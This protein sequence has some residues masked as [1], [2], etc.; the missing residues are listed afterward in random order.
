MSTLKKALFT[1]YQAADLVEAAYQETE[2]EETDETRNLEALAELG[3][4]DA[5]ERIAAFVRHCEL[6]R[7]NVAA[8]RERLAETD[9]RIAK[10]ET[11]GR[12]KIREILERLEKTKATAGAFKIT[13]R[14]GSKRCEI[15][16]PEALRE[17][18]TLRELP[19]ELV[20]VTPEKVVPES[21]KLDKRAALAALKKGQAVT[22]CELVTGE[23]SIK[24][25]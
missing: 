5:L 11:W 4:Y 24:V 21:R 23:R 2:G 12:G 3:A 15:V 10:A 7:E 25:S 17:A 22:G 6:G 18:L 1:M 13:T 20:N 14:A 16:D 9:K 8:E 19:D